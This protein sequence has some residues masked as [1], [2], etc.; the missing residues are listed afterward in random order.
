[1]NKQASTISKNTSLSRF[2]MAVRLSRLENAYS[3]PILTSEVVQTD[4]VFGV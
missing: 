3:H 1:M 4:L 2:V